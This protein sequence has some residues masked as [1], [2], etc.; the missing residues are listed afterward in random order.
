MSEMKLN[1]L[2]NIYDNIQRG[3]ALGK[4]LLMLQGSAR[5]GKTYNTMIFIILECLQHPVRER[6]VIDPESLKK[7]KINEP[8]KVSVVRE[9][10]PVIKRSVYNDFKTIMMQIGEWDDRCMN[11]TDY[12]YSF[13]NGATIEFFSAEDEQKLRGP[14]RHILYINEANEINFYSFS[15][16]RQR[17][18]EYVIVDYNPSFTEEH[19]LFPLMTDERTYHFISTYKD[20][21]FLP[22]AAVQEIESYKETNPALWQIFGCGKFAIVDGLVF[23]KENWDIISDDDFPTWSNEGFLGID[24]GYDPDPTV[25]LRVII[26]GDDVYVHEVLRE[27]KLLSKDIAD[28]LRPYRGLIKYCDIDKRLVA[29]LDMAGIPLLNKTIKNGESIL[30]GIRLLNMR[31]IHITASSTDLIK[32][33]KNYV[34]KK[35]RGGTYMTDENPVD[36]FSHGPDALRYVILAEFSETY[37]SRNEREITKADL[38]IFM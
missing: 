25:A 19:W 5:S 6:E 30:T 11:K 27:T 28:K 24:W 34:Y 37:A 16:L 4:T 31:K 36:K 1:I 12:I 15:M 23:P 8:L 38:G 3:L 10:L 7:I 9:S 32:E 35:D 22:E 26:E 13:K 2:A 20:N 29:E 18:Y 14:W 17:T 33:F 21:I